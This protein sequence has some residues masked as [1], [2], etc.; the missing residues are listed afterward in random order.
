MNNIQLLAQAYRQFL[1]QLGRE[2][3]LVRD[4]ASYEG[5]ADTFIDAVKSPEIGFTPSEVQTLIKMYD[6]FCLLDINDLPSHHSM[7]MMVNKKVDMDVLESAKTLSV[8]DFKE[9]LKDKELGTQDRSYKY[10]IIKRVVESGSI[11]RVYGEELDEAL[12][13]LQ[14]NAGLR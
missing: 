2:F 8:T 14:K 4:E 11:R 12:K 1:L 5:Y 3:K 9:S 6:M 13:Q 7:K 10:E